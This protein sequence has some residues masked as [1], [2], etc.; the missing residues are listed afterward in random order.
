[1]ILTKGDTI[2]KLNKHVMAMNLA[3]VIA[4]SAVA[5][6]FAPAVASGDIVAVAAT[7]SQ[8]LDDKTTVEIDG[9]AATITAVDKE[10]KSVKLA[11]TVKD[12]S[13]KEVP[14]T[15]IDK[16]AF[17]D[18]KATKID[19]RQ[20]A[21]TSLVANQFKGAKKAKTIIINGSKLKKVSPKAFK[22]LKS[23]KTIKVKCSKK[24]F[25]KLQAALIKAAK[26]SGAKKAPKVKRI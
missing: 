12:A 14:V 18:S 3:A 7:S 13:G 5:G 17:K 19:A 23:L 26:K 10:A 15:A 9:D 2:M 20:V 8:T 1:M 25:K 24:Q 11:G 4:F 22:G 21:V 6:I 16:N